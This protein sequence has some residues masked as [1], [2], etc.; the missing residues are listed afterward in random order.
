MRTDQFYTL[1]LSSFKRDMALAGSLTFESTLPLAIRTIPIEG[2]GM[3]CE[4]VAGS[5]TQETAGGC[6]NFPTFKNNPA[7]CVKLAS[8]CEVQMRI[9]IRA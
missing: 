1:V 6:Q 4:R 5:W 2:W 3:A 9:C 8:D 7:Y